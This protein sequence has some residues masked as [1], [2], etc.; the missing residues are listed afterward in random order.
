MTGDRGGAVALAM[1]GSIPTSGTRLKLRN[2]EGRMEQIQIREKF[3]DLLI[4][5]DWDLDKVKK[6]LDRR[7]SAIKAEKL[8]L[9]CKIKSKLKLEG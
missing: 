7:V 9:Q 2:L 8:E 6:E 5:Y 1:V 3:E 4:R